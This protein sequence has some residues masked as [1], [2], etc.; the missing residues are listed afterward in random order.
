M[1]ST[2]IMPTLFVPCYVIVM[3]NLN[4]TPSLLSEALRILDRWRVDHAAQLGLLGMPDDMHP[5]M[6]RRARNGDST[7]S[8]DSDLLTRIR[9]IFEIHNTL[10]KMF[11]HNLQMADYWVTTPNRQLQE[12]SPLEL[13]L[14]NG[15]DGMQTVTQ[16]LVSADHW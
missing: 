10:E 2:G 11:P 13:M 9:S 16:Q 7:L 5:R 8:E 6:L 12:R 1:Q 14:A 3:S 4:D 15:L